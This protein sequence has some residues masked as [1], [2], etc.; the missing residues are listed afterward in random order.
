MDITDRAYKE[1]I[2]F[3]DVD[4]QYDFINHKGKLYVSKAEEIVPN[5]KAITD[6]AHK[7]NIPIISTVDTHKKN[8]PEFKMF[9]QH[10]QAKTPGAKKISQT[11]LKKN[12]T[13]TLGEKY[14][15]EDL[16]RIKDTWTQIIVE[17]D[18]IDVFN[19]PI[20]ANL[21][22]VIFPSTVYVYGVATEYC[23]KKAVL[24]LLKFVDKV[25]VVED[26]IKEIN[27]KD[28]E[29]TFLEFR[30]NNVQFINTAKLLEMV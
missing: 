5:L 15:F 6:L 11:L 14:P 17:K 7:N 12:K 30:K 20:L 2:L 29:K 4:T 27:S 25:V 13:L 28:K 18:T 9:P 21:F 26:A 19:S 1:N 23:V 10:C 16:I 3:L 8:D 24:G 22:S